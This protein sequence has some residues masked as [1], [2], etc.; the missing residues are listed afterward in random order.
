MCIHPE[1]RTYISECVGSIRPVLEK[2]EVE[3]VVV[4]VLSSEGLP[5]EK[6]VFE[7]VQ[8]PI[9]PQDIRY[10]N[11]TYNAAVVSGNI[12]CGSFISSSS[13]PCFSW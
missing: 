4:V 5:V 6:F 10:Y 3:K 7:I 13:S 2:G 1:L 9:K 12:T 11:H 8:R